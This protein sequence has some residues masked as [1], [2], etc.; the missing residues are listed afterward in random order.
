MIHEKTNCFIFIPKDSK[1]G[2]DFRELELSGPAQAV[3][4]CK[5][6][7]TSMI[8]LAL[9]GR[10]PYSNSLFYPYID[11]VTG[12]PIIDPG[13]MSQLDPNA[14]ANGVLNP[15]EE[16]QVSD[17]FD[18]LHCKNKEKENA[19][20]LIYNNGDYHDPSNYDLYYQSLYQMYPQMADY[21][22]KAKEFNMNEKM[23]AHQN[24]VAPFIFF[25]AGIF[26]QESQTSTNSLYNPN[27]ISI[28]HDMIAKPEEFQKKQTEEEHFDPY[29]IKSDVTGGKK[30]G[31]SDKPVFTKD[32]LNKYIDSL[33][34]TNKNRKVTNYDKNTINDSVNL[35]YEQIYTDEEIKANKLAEEQRNL[36]NKG[37][38]FEQVV[39]RKEEAQQ[40]QEPM[41]KQKKKRPSRFDNPQPL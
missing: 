23:N 21:Y 20:Y 18:Y 24:V 27:Y 28:Y 25:N 3:E 14:I 10:L 26:D 33:Y 2:E 4:L 37:E 38:G 29:G 41:D 36:T 32:D 12:L 22:R 13:I 19:D 7:I 31:F 39:T 16:N 35:Y 15:Y 30:G 5:K 9:Y 1:P 40:F 11:P 17:Y 34:T 8:H 6:E